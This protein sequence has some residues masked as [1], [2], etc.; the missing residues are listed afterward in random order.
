MYKDIYKS[1]QS[2]MI[3]WPQIVRSYQWKVIKYIKPRKEFHKKTS[4]FNHLD[5][6]RMMIFENGK[7][8]IEVVKFME[9]TLKSISYKYIW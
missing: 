9:L 5:N 7:D 6:R 4:V 2:D 8:R 3:N 1:S